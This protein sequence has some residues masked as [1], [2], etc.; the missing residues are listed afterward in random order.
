M[1]TSYSDNVN[2]DYLLE[3]RDTQPP[4][5]VSRDQAVKLSQINQQAV[6]VPP[7][8]M[9]QATKQNADE[10]FIEGLTEFFTKAK[11]ATYGKLKTAVFN[12][13]GVNEETGGLFELGIKGAFLGVRE[14]YED[15]I[16]QPLRSVELISQGVDSKEAWKKAAIDPFAYWKEARARGEK[17][18]L[19]NALFQSTD[20]EKT[21][22][23]QNLIDKGADPIKA[24]EIAISR[25][26][27]NIFDEIFEAEKKVVFD[28]DR[29]AALIA[30]GKS[31]HVT[32][33]RVLFKAF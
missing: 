15:V 23:Y 18:D 28:G 21:L 29:A 1:A 25:L 19:G 8:V 12:Q 10:G 13:F 17:I 30:R 7:S 26:G 31:P 32:P 22:T 20:P 16:G 24:R 33:G 2:V 4:L 6:N 27:A 9:V 14:L 5:Q 3:K 11:A